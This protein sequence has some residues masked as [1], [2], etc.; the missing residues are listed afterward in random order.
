MRFLIQSGPQRRWTTWV[1]LAV[2][3]AI[4]GVLASTRPGRRAGSAPAAAS[5]L[6][7]VDADPATPRAGDLVVTAEAMELAEIRVAASVTRVV[8]EKFAV[9]GTIEAGGDRLVKITPRVTGKIVSVAAVVGDPVRAG[10]TLALLESSELSAA[11]AE[12]EQARIGLSLARKTLARQRKLA[13]LGAFGTPALE[14]S[15]RDAIAAR[16]DVNAATSEVAAAKH[17]VAEARSEIAAREGDVASAEADVTSADSRVAEAENQIG[18]LEAALAQAHAQVKVTQAAFERATRLLE[19]GIVSRGQQEQEEAAFRR[20]RADVDAAHAN[21]RQGG[22]RIAT[23]KAALRAAQAK[24]TAAQAKQRQAEAAV[25]SASAREE[26]AA[27][28]LASGRRQ[29]EIAE[30]S[31]RREEAVARG[32]YRTSK[33][34]LEAYGALQEEELR[35][36]SSDRAVRL[37]GGQPGGVSRIPVTTSIAGRVQERSVSVGETVVVDRTLFSVINLDL[38]WAQLSVT[39]RD[40]PLVRV[41][42]RV[43]LVADSAPGRT[44]TGTVSA[45]GSAA[46]ETTRAVRVRCALVNKGGA[47]RPE[48]FV[49][50]HVVT[51]VRRERVV[52]PTGALQEHTGKPTVYIKNADQPGGFEVRH[53][54]LGVQGEGWWEIADGLKAG[55]QVAVNGT[56]YLKSEALKSFLSDG[57]C[58]VDKG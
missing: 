20:A 8:A 39:P 49:R 45:L 6:A 22:S 19:S 48:T 9:N 34:I 2:V 47:L 40:L 24:V 58:A 17:A 30:Q 18:A 51:D 33:E 26:Q 37:L 53:V 41:G 43:E 15:R 10:Q 14:Q 21:I 25:D 13:D 35:V 16:G 28:R 55:E 54:T 3:A 52:V 1:A 50:G 32:Y 42:Q 46:D 57:C 5:W 11:Q 31:L 36:Q 7:G 56:F 4:I 38:V 44:F 12:C 27:W 29:A 23:E